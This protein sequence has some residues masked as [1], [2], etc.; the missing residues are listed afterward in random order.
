MRTKEIYN[1]DYV[2]Y[3][4][5]RVWSNKTNKFMSHVYVGRSRNYAYVGFSVNGKQ[6]LTSVHRLLG[7]CFIPN[8]ENKPEI[9][10]KDGNPRN[11]SL[12]NLEWNTRR[13]NCIHAYATGLMDKNLKT[14]QCK[15]GEMIR[16][17]TEI[18]RK[19]RENKKRQ[20]AHILLVDKRNKEADALEAKCKSEKDRIF[21]KYWR[22]GMTYVEIGKEMNCTRQ[23]V[24]NRYRIIRN[25]KTLMATCGK[26]Y[27]IK[28]PNANVL[29]P[30]LSA[31]MARSACSI[32][33]LAD[34]LKISGAALRYKLSGRSE[35]RFSECQK[36]IKLFNCSFEYLFS[37]E[38]PKQRIVL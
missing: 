22:K 4:D 1:G 29:Y 14:K 28:N 9:N 8:P 13:E 18:C 31:E 17:R 2:V 20:K 25:R 23:A 32:A 33:G 10:H 27:L 5:G 19:C 35:F 21:L 24:E 7:Q 15:C 34:I 16:P 6:R 30:N 26:A 36:L 12:D 37:Y 38:Q 3:E 11:N